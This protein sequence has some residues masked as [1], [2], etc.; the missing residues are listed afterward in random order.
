MIQA[1]AWRAWRRPGCHVLMHDSGKEELDAL[2]PGSVFICS[3]GTGLSIT[4]LTT[5]Y[6]V[7]NYF[8][9]WLTD[10]VHMILRLNIW[11]LVFKFLKTHSLGHSIVLYLMQPL[12]SL[13][14]GAQPFWPQDFCQKYGTKAIVKG[15]Q[16]HTKHTGFVCVL[17]ITITSI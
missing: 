2:H 15:H 13:I 3:Q 4:W 7:S 10:W 9:F 5:S 16:G 14:L 6:Q 8:K 1:K 12:N 11:T 17:D